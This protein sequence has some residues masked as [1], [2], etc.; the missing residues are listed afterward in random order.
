LSTQLQ[1]KKKPIYNGIVTRIRGNVIDAFFDAQIPPM[2]SMLSIDAKSKI[3]VEVVSFPKPNLVRTIAFTPTSGCYRGA[4]ISGEGLSLQVPVGDQVLGRMLN[5]FGETTD[6]KEPIT[7]AKR[8]SIYQPSTQLSEQ[9]TTSEIFHTGIKAL[10]LLAPLE[11]GGKAGLFGGAGVGKTVLITELINNTVKNHDGVS[12][13]CGIGERSREAEELYHEMISA[14]V[15]DHTIMVFGQMNEPPGVR[16][17]VGH[18]ALSIAE[19]FRDDKKQDVLLLIDNIFRF[20]QAG[21]EVSGLLGKMPSRVGY[22]PTLASEMASLQERITNTKN[23]AITSIQAVYVPA[24]DFTDPSA[25]H[26][27]SHFSASIILSRKRA[28]EGLYPAID[29][30]RSTSKMLSPDIVGKRHYEVALQV[31][32]T[33][34]EFEE[35]KDIIVMLGLEELSVKDRRVVQRARRL[36]RFLTQPFV[37]TEQFTGIE[38]TLVSLEDTL[39]GCERILLDEFAMISESELYMIG[40]IQDVDQKKPAEEGSDES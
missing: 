29:P 10:D 26:T 27:F 36:E 23:G 3:L 1:S 19:Y 33:L 39:D 11:R 6:D 28:S 21:S 40:S 38:G 8:R 31:R 14:G 37:T 20:V 13:F 7:D 5:V 30:L 16:F 34:A 9:M 22:Q 24:D 17:R 32:K 25:T 15:L 2:H 35:L 18:A 12:I 4:A